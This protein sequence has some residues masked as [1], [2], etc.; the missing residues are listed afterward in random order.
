MRIEPAPSKSAASAA[1][2]GRGRHARAADQQPLHRLASASGVIG[3]HARQPFT[4]RP[5]REC[6]K[7]RSPG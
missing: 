6:W 3:R 1:S 2:V 5:E 4:F 7:R